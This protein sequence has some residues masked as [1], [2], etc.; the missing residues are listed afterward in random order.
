[1]T[2][3][4][5]IAVIGGACAGS[6]FASKLAEAGHHVVVFEQN[7]LP[8]GKIEDGL[9]RWHQ[10]LQRREMGLID[11]RL[12]HERITFV[13][14]HKL[15]TDFDLSE[16]RE[17][18]GFQLV[19][20]ANGAWR[21]RTLK[22]PGSEAIKDRSLVEQNPFVYWFNHYPDSNYAGEVFNVPE[23]AVIFGGGLASIDVAKICQFENFLR[24][25]RERGID[26]NVVQLEHYGLE[27]TAIKHGLS[28]EDLSFEPATIVYRRQ[29]ED[30]PLVPL[31]DDAD[32]VRLEKAKRTREKI[33]ANACGR[34]G[35]R[36]M[37]LHKPEEIEHENGSVTGVVLRKTRIEQG[38]VIGCEELTRL[39]TS[40]IISSVGSIPENLPGLPMNGEL[41]DTTDA[42][43]GRLSKYD[44]IYCAG[45]AITGKG[46]I[47]ASLKSAQS[48]A[49]ISLAGLSEDAIQRA[50]LLESQQSAVRP[51]VEELLSYA[52][53]LSSVDA[54]I[55]EQVMQRTAALHG[56]INYTTYLQWCGQ[57]LAKRTQG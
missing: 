38:R 28:M 23:G 49:R 54:S 26:E 48:L 41:Y 33:V 32:E 43:T 27:K 13:P 6:E 2:K 10:K 53:N 50:E 51:F 30:M 31:N 8:Y 46:N 45:N 20:L 56:K 22:I 25:L 21:D 57:V 15:G 35:F 24:K 14:C 47:K 44:G 4:T 19:V 5:L 3:S 55:R 18:W 1:M 29:I 40:L 12:N 34:Y 36:V 52:E 16:L 11:D 9:P 39:N 7:E 37:P 42:T 17:Q